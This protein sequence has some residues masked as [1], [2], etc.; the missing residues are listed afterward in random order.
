MVEKVFPLP[1]LLPVGLQDAYQPTTV[2]GIVLVKL[3]T[4]LVD[5]QTRLGVAI[6]VI[7]GFG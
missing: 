6:R 1:R 7:L 2:T 4:V 3:S 5:L